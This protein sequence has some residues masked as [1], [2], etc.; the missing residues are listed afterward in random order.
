[1]INSEI[2]SFGDSILMIACEY[3]RIE[4]IKHLIN[5]SSL[6]SFLIA[7]NEKQIL[8]FHPKYPIV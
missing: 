1:M 7:E 3:S 4:I 2:L 6:L 5:T 8:A